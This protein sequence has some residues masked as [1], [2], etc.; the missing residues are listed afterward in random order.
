[1]IYC[2]SSK[3]KSRT[4]I[5]PRIGLADSSSFLGSLNLGSGRLFR[6]KLLKALL[7]SPGYFLIGIAKTA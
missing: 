4:L 5:G 1:M 7:D 2:L 6:L 3:I